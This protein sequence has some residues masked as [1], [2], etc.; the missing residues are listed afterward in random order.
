MAAINYQR[1]IQGHGWL[2]VRFQLHPDGEPND[3][4]L[5]ARMM[6]NDNQLQQEAIGELGVN[7]VYA[8]YF[9]SDN[10]D[11][12]VQS[13][14]DGLSGRVRI[15]MACLSGPD[16]KQFDNR[17]MSLKLVQHDLTEVAM[18]GPGGRPVHPSE[19]MYKKSVMVVRGNYRPPTVVS[20]D[21]FDSA[22]QMFCQEEPVDPDEAELLAEITLQ[23]LSEET[24]IDEDD[25]I[26]RAECLCALGKTT[27]I[28][29]CEH[30]QVLI[31]YLSEYKIKQLGLVIGARELLALIEGKYEQ[32]KEGRL[33]VAFGELF[34]K[35]IRVYAYPALEDETG[36]LMT[37][38]NLPVPEGIK[39][40]YKHLI[41]SQY[42][43]DVKGVREE[44]LHIM[45]P[46]IYHMI[47]SGETGWEEA[48]PSEIA[49]VIE[50]KHLFGYAL[51]SEK[52]EV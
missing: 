4:V 14:N 51:Q 24:N 6:D 15:D 18:F 11:H 23:N 21:V 12:F 38:K 19:F 37:I 8:C 43:V 40:L 44:L 45:P 1:T 2:G 30:H 7:M 9:Y 31:N 33:L 16:F 46:D 41:D 36:E 3:F 17:L 13:L 28:S 50:D 5:H 29:N 34:T 35:N 48:G 27:I 20:L 49:R 47:Q 26:S 25:F 22:F 10:L 52:S 39:F 42:I 32:N